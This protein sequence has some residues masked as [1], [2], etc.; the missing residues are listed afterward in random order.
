MLY[1][2]KAKYNRRK[3]VKELWYNK[4]KKKERKKRIESKIKPGVN[5]VSKEHS[6][7]CRRV[8]P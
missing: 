5:V 7:S 4:K 8:W 6:E 3:I 2:I 1:G